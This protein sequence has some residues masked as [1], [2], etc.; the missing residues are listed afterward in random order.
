VGA[1]LTTGTARAPGDLRFGDLV[2][3]AG[4][5]PG[6]GLAERAAAAAGAGF[7]ALSLFA[8]DYAGARAR[9]L[10]DAD[11]RALLR[12]H[13]LIVAELDPLLTWLP[14]EPSGAGLS[15]E[16]HAFRAHG[17]DTFYAIAQALG[18][19]GLNAVLADP[20]GDLERV[21]GAFAGL[22]DR[23][24]RHGLLVHL[25]FLPWTRIGDAATAAAVVARAGR[26]NGGVMLDAWHH[27]RSGAPHA[28]IPAASVTAIQLCDA[29]ARPE[30]DPVEETLHRRR[31][32]GEG[33]TDLAGLLRHL[34]A[35][36]CRAPIGVEVFSDQL[37]ARPVAEAA[38]R[39]AET[40][41]RV[42]ADAGIAPR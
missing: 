27:A 17:E 25:E 6:S 5:V 29:P 14:E 13:G 1:A 19:R 39:A 26:P 41:R 18:A 28:T 40:T 37:A 12:D 21:S 20:P 11:L 33:E 23:A 7:S 24:A 22:C 16:G 2:L 8:D 3:C 31:L 15:A 32:P 34:A 42:L 30:P 35:G 4:T 36:G 9:G 10:S 38:R